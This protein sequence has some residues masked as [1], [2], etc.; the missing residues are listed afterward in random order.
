[1]ALKGWQQ[2][3]LEAEQDTGERWT[4]HLQRRVRQT[5]GVWKLSITADSSTSKD[6][7]REL[8][9]QYWL[10][11]FQGNSEPQMFTLQGFFLIAWQSVVT[12]QENEPVSG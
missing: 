11:D 4:N 2:L 7:T 1:M 8:D 9:D 5:P 3:P 6:V 12:K 10:L